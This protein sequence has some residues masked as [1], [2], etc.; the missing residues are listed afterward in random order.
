M[1]CMISGRT[2]TAAWKRFQIAFLL[3]YLFCLTQVRRHHSFTEV[4]LV[5]S[6]ETA[7]NGAVFLGALLKGKELPVLKPL[8]MSGFLFPSLKHPLFGFIMAHEG[9]VTDCGVWGLARKLKIL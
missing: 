9:I 4:R 1:A 8:K 3:R 2:P 5:R 7:E 6:P